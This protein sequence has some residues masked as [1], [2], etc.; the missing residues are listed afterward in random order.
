MPKRVRREVPNSF[1]DAYAA[2][3]QHLQSQLGDNLAVQA[4]PP[5]SVPVTPAS[6][7]QKA[8]AWNTPHP[9]ATDEAM[10]GLAQQKYAEHR[11]AGLPEDKAIAATAEDLTH[12]RY[13]ARQPLYSLGTTS[14]GEQV[15]EAKRLA[16]LASKQG[17]EQGAQPPGVPPAE[18]MPAPTVPAPAGVV[19]PMGAPAEPVAS[20]LP[21]G[22]AQPAPPLPGASPPSPPA[23]QG[24]LTH[25]Y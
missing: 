25:G 15:A 22:P 19:P 14:W 12:F 17:E 6:D 7:R 2:V 21:A 16:R 8:E 9:Q 11:G 10:W 13:R 20:P 23:S 1:A 5:T 24:G 18:E 3:A 4:G